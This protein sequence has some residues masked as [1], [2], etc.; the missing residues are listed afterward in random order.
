MATN[1]G[2]LPTVREERRDVAR[3]FRALCKQPPTRFPMR[4]QCK[5]APIEKGVY[6]IRDPGG[7]VVHVGSTPRA[8]RGLCQRL[9]NHLA[10]ISSFAVKYL[11]PRR[12]RLR[13]GY[14]FQYLVEKDG[15]KR[16]LLEAYA[17][18][19]LCPAHLGTG[20]KAA[21]RS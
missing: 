8:P 3:L 18:A 14:T 13:D 7:R 12:L 6:V 15:R 16:T 10:G 21:D 9:G 19:R 4:G 1:S 5:T 11:A 2:E 20:G 17:T